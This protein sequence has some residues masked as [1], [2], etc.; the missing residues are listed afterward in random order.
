M[1]FTPLIKGLGLA[2]IC[3]ICGYVYLKR[4]KTDKIHNTAEIMVGK[5]ELKSRMDRIIE[6]VKTCDTKA[7]IM[8]TLVCLVLSFVFTSDF[9]IVGFSKIIQSLRLYFDADGGCNIRDISISGSFSIA[10][11]IG[12]LYFTFGSIYRFV[13]VLY[14]KISESQIEE[15]LNKRVYK[16]ANWLFKYSP[17]SKSTSD[18]YMNSLIHFNNIAKMDDFSSFKSAMES[19]SDNEN[20]DLLSQI[21]INANRCKEKFDDYNAAIRWMLYS[22]PF[23]LLLLISLSLFMTYRG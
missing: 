12:Y 13:M 15:G 18:A 14:S 5:D 16:F 9:F 22:F 21:Y 8:L 23:L 3:F 10:F 1:T 11:F 6:W 7:S 19:S 4:K 2:T 17:S 20:E